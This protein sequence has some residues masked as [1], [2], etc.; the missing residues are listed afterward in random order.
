M[1]SPKEKIRAN[2]YKQLLAEEK[3]KG[4]RKGVYSFSLFLLGIFVNSAYQVVTR[5]NI[6]KVAPQQQITNVS[7][8]SKLEDG[9]S[10]LSMEHLYNSAFFEDKDLDLTTD[11]LFGLDAKISEVR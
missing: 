9:K 6:L 11:K 10:G 1:V 4:K 8:V 7:K 2:I 3:R 5:E